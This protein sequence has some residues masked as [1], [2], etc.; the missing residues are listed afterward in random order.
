MSTG[1]VDPDKTWY[2]K[3]TDSP[4]ALKYVQEKIPSAKI[5]IELTGEK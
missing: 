4:D 2:A 1:H 3:V 5:L